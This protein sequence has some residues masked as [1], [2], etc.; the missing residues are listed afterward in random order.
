[1][2]VFLFCLGLVNGHV[3]KFWLLLH[4]EVQHVVNK[5]GESPLSWVTI[6]VR[7]LRRV[8]LLTIYYKPLAIRSRKWLHVAKGAQYGQTKE[9]I[10]HDTGIHNMT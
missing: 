10:L 6:D 7:L 8:L 4:L 1:M 9:Y 3:P 2:L 5:H